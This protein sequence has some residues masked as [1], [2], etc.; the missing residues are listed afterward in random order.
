MLSAAQNPEVVEQYLAKEVRLGRVVGPMSADAL[1]GVQVSRFGVIPKSH[2]P[3][4][5]GLLLTFLIQGEQG[6]ADSTQCTYKSTQNRYLVFCKEGRLSGTKRCKAEK[7]TKGK[8]RLPI[9]PGILRKLKH[10][11][12]QTAADPDVQMLWAACTL[13][14]SAFL[15]T[16]EMTVPSDKGYDP[17]SHLS[18]GDIAVDNPSAPTLMRVQIKQSKTDPFRKGVHL[19]V[20][21]TSL[22]V[23]PVA[24]MLKYLVARGWEKGPLFKFRDGRPLT[25]Q[26]LVDALR[27]ALT[28]V[29]LDQSKYCGHSF[30]I[31]AATT[32]AAKGIEDS[33]IQT[34]GRW[35]SLAYL[36]YVWI[37]R[38]QLANYLRV[39][40]AYIGVG[41][42]FGRLGVW[43]CHSLGRFMGWGD[44]PQALYA[45][46]PKPPTMH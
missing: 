27:A 16:G 30:R 14:F 38:D 3:G 4:S 18:F 13:A 7:G 36:Q 32:A 1:P 9:T 25:H 45:P 22:E 28:R 35:R 24:A 26:H 44:F 46:G 23:C 6:L 40:C 33:I 43:C 2:H 37:P 12:S 41:I 29:G 11:W 8:E 5:G 20:G 42:I 34:L 10:S 17:A 39:L 31:R 15:R 19:F 21:R